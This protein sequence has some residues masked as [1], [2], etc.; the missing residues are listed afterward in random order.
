MSALP[1]PQSRLDFRLQSDHKALIERAARLH[2]QTV[3]QFAI[4]A[5][6]KAARESIQDASVTELSL[7]DRDI[8]LSMLDEQ[9]E[10]NEALKKAAERYRSHRE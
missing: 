10:P 7:R 1:N 8:F 3:T 4:A 5:L 2:G 9:A 6:L